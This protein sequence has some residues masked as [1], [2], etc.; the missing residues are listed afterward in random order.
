MAGERRRAGDHGQSRQGGSGFDV[1]SMPR[2]RQLLDLLEAAGAPVRPP[3]W[4][5]RS[6]D[7][8]DG[9]SAIWHPGQSAT[10][11]LG[12]KTVL[13]E[14]G[15]LHPSARPRRSTSTALVGRRARS[16]STLSPPN[17]V[18]APVRDALHPAGAAIGQPRL[19][20]PRPRHAASRRSRPQR[21]AAQTRRC[22]TD[23][24]LFDRFA[25]QGVPEGQLSLAVDSHAATRPTRASPMP[26]SRRSATKLSPPPPSWVRC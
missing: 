16:F 7:S 14:F 9:Q 17:A 25:G 22:I 18:A 5:C 11:R 26:R 21:C 13:A 19:C 1:P 4:S 12:P 20:L 24:R 2:R 3:A 6:K 10:L 8:A 23:A 15:A